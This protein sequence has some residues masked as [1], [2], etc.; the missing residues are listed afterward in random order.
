MDHATGLIFIFNQVSLRAGENI[1]GRK[2]FEHFPHDHGITTNHI[3]GDNE[4]FASRLSKEH[5]NSK[6]KIYDFSGSGAH[7]QNSV[8]ENIYSYSNIIGV[9]NSDPLGAPFSGSVNQ[10]TITMID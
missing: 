5:C 8:T 1:V 9:R 3:H 4:V 2:K 10:I 7:H 6:G